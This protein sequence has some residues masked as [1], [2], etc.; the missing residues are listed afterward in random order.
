VLAWAE[1]REASLALAELLQDGAPIEFTAWSGLAPLRAR[2]RD[3]DVLVPA[4]L[5]A[6]PVSLDEGWVLD[7]LSAY[8]DRSLLG[9]QRGRAAKRAAT[10]AEAALAAGGVGGEWP[11]RLLAASAGIEA[12][13]LLRRA[14]LAADVRCALAACVALEQLGETAPEAVLERLAAEPSSRSR[15]HAELEECGRLAS[16]PSPWATQ[17]ALAESVMVDWLSFPT[18]LGRPPTAIELVDRRE[19][20]VDGQPGVIYVFRFRS[21]LDDEAARR[22]WMIGVAGAFS[23][24]GA[25][26][27][28]TEGALTFSEF[29]PED[30]MTLDEH[31]ELLVG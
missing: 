2:P 23:S 12:L 20:D 15:L 16:F 31:L 5:G 4:L 27:T 6:D 24:A 18:E 19:C 11:V 10:G 13:P 7:V 29:V 14:A 17:E 8:A 30:E 26:T 1:S 22:G 25:P 21:A 3:A 28:Q 9:D